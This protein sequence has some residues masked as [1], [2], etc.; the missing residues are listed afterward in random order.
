MSAASD[1]FDRWIRSGFIEM[2]TALEH[3]Y[4][5]LPDPAAVTGT[6]DVIKV[7]LRD[8]GQAHVAALWA[9]SNTGDGF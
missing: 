2:N 9:G 7:A 6:G 1:A 3:L 4:A 5:A 8:E